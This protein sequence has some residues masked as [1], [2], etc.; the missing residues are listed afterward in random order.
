MIMTK[1]QLIKPFLKE[2]KCLSKKWQAIIGT[3]VMIVFCLVV[4]LHLLLFNSMP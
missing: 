1:W 4:V 2:E 3:I